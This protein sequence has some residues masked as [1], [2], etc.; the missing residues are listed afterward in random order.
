MLILT[1]INP[2]E[3]AAVFRKG[4]EKVAAKPGQIAPF[5]IIVPVGD[6]D[7]APGPA[8]SELK[9]AG[10][11]AMI[12][13]GKIAV[14]KD[15]TVAKKGEKI[16]LAVAK[17]LMTLGIK[18]LE[19]RMYLDAALE[20]D[21]LYTRDSLEVDEEKVLADL[22]K[23]MQ[24]A[25]NLSINVAYPTSGNVKLLLGKAFNEAKG[26]AIK[27]GAYEPEVMDQVLAKALAE[28]KAL[29]GKVNFNEV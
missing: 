25:N 6:T 15:S 20:N 3:L 18:P 27:A 8:L 10:I 13:A 4:K 26:L 23:A 11:N 9:N 21:V 1:N 16:P 5:D 17:A 29:A 19:S 28:A 12:K 14:Q 7:L 2:F 22:V 24:L